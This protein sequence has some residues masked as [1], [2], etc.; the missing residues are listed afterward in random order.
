MV[1]TL[2]SN[3]GGVGLIPGWGAKIPHALHPKIQNK[4]QK[5]YC[6]KFNEDFKKIIKLQIWSA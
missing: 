4:E 5:K 2:P 1:K 6:N 3:A